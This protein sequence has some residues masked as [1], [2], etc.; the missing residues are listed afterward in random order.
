MS[1][2][3]AKLATVV[4]GALMS[5]GLVSAPAVAPATLGSNLP[6]S[7]AL[8]DTYLAS[9]IGTTDSSMTL[10]KGTTNDGIS[11]SG[12]MCFT[13]DVNSPQLEYVC[14]TASGTAVTS[15]LRGIGFSNPNT[16]S[17]AL[18]FTHRRFA[19]VQSTDYPTLQLIVRQLTG[20]D[21]LASGSILRYDPG[22]TNALVNA[23][24]QN[25]A[26]VGFVASSTISGGVPATTVNA[27]IVKLATS[28]DLANGNTTTTYGL[29]ADARFFSSSSVSS[30]NYQVPVA[31]SG[32]LANGF[33]NH[34]NQTFTSTTFNATTTFAS[35]TS[36]LIYATST[37][38]V[39]GLGIG[40][41]LSISGGNLVSASAPTSSNA[42]E[43]YSWSLRNTSTT[44]TGVTLSTNGNQK[45]VI[46]YA[47]QGT[48]GGSGSQ[49]NGSAL[50]IYIDGASVTSAGCYSVQ[51]PGVDGYGCSAAFISSVL[52]NATHTVQAH[53]SDVSSA[54]SATL[55]GSAIGVIYAITVQ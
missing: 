31:V 38:V 13:L 3:F 26:T 19:S 34:T 46:V 51:S 7:P 45:L 43:G 1:N 27:G 55:S 37:G 40:T 20:V 17:S 23:N 21:T 41:N 36:K 49:P 30:T 39:S 33:V 44:S 24:N 47:G 22:I 11:L 2:F 4:V 48:T 52:S 50:A 9:N 6:S 53:F 5:I 25:L 28:T 12:Y 18:A 14:G 16:T 10:A 8:V 32:T 42:T 15:M 29:V 54:G 35:S